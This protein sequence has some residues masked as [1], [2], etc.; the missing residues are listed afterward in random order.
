MRLLLAL[1]AALLVVAPAVGEPARA[2]RGLAG[3][4]EVRYA[5][6]LRARA[7]QS[8]LSPVCVRVVSLPAG[9]AQKVEFIGTVAGEFD[10]RDFIERQDGGPID[11]LAP[12]PVTIVTTLPPGHGPDLY[13]GEQS[14]LTWRAHYREL[15]WVAGIAWACVPIIVLARRLARRRVKEPAAPPAPA[16][17]LEDQLLAA[18]DAA[19]DAPSPEQR[20]RLELLMLR[21]LGARLGR[22]IVPEEDGAATL[23]MLR[24]RPESR[25]LVEAV[26]RWLH[27]RDSGEP[28]R[29][30]ARASLESL[31]RTSLDPGTHRTATEGAA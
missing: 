12:I 23:R 1:V 10:L 17:T 28:A 21:Y 22:P 6:P 4:V 31:R 25:P 18:L 5:H 30:H 19:G 3:V 24:E 8:P 9:G 13:G 16:P 29:S 14:W 27:A 20:G 26:E 11:D 2:D 15:L 7:N